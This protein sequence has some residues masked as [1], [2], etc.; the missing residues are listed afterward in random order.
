V[1]IISCINAV[2][3]WRWQLMDSDLNTQD[4]QKK[5]EHKSNIYKCCGLECFFSIGAYSGHQCHQVGLILSQMN[6]TLGTLFSES[7][8]KMLQRGVIL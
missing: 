2:S 1:F 3:A 5:E 4:S 7:Q 6:P 8:S